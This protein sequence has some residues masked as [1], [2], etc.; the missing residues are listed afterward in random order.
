MKGDY[1]CKIA[2]EI[3]NIVFDPKSETIVDVSYPTFVDKV[4]N[5]AATLGL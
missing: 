4:H 1:L 2:T 3:A 5:R